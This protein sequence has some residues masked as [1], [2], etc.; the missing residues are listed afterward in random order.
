MGDFRRHR[1]QFHAEGGFNVW[2]GKNQAP[3]ANRQGQDGWGIGNRILPADQRLAAEPGQGQ[4]DWGVGNRILP[5][6]QRKAYQGGRRQHRH[7]TPQ[8][9]WDPWSKAGGEQLPPPPPQQQ[10][11]Q[12]QQAP[13]VPQAHNRPPRNLA[14][15]QVG[16]QH[17]PQ[18]QNQVALGSRSV[19]VLP[20]RRPL[21]D[22][23]GIGNRALPDKPQ[24]QA[25]Q[26]GWGLGNR[27]IPDRPHH[28]QQP[29]LQLQQAPAA[30]SK[31]LPANVYETPQY[32]RARNMVGQMNGPVGLEDARKAGLGAVGSHAHVGAGLANLGGQ[33]QDSS[34]A[35]QRA[36]MLADWDAQVAVKNREKEQAK[37][38]KRRQDIADLIAEAKGGSEVCAKA[39]ENMG[40]PRSQWEDPSAGLPPVGQ[41]PPQAQAPAFGRRQVTPRPA[42]TVRRPEPGAAVEAE[43]QA[44]SPVDSQPPE[45]GLGMIE[46]L[47]HELQADKHRWNAEVADYEARH[48]KRGAQSAR[49]LRSES[50]LVYSK[51]SD[52]VGRPPIVDSA[53]GGGRRNSVPIDVSALHGDQLDLLLQSFLNRSRSNR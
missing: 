19:P 45:G 25:Q 17:I 6:H 35:A 3:A 2:N 46:D 40:V 4:D 39:L 34:A 8:P 37:M 50:Q 7:Q 27:I 52:A 53:G 22:P 44:P 14:G 23:W 42:A 11:Q 13:Y 47:Y 31:P 15:Q 32:Y 36:A 12:L 28:Q 21:A 10:Q 9:I 38:E 41:G 20:P 49:E 51:W 1:S 30:H 26:Q 18:A 16:Y 43:L 24:P 33:Q 29:Q 48:A 5:D